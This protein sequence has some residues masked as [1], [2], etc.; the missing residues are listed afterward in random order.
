MAKAV[1]SGSSLSQEIVDF[2]LCVLLI[3]I[4]FLAGKFFEEI[5]AF[6]VERGIIKADQSQGYSMVTNPG[7]HDP[8]N[9][10]ELAE[11]AEEDEDDVSSKYK[12]ACNEIQRLNQKIAELKKNNSEL[13]SQNT[14]LQTMIKPDQKKGE[15]FQEDDD[16]DVKGILDN[17]DNFFKEFQ[18]GE[19]DGHED[20]EEE[21]DIKQFL[22]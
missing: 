17:K 5:K 14:N 10:T 11:I 19:K 12:D 1:A 2:L 18:D 8:E 3:G 6:L 22:K 15:K 21:E 20:N 7:R 16:E 9:V 13:E 4:G